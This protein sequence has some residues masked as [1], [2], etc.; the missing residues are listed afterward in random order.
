MAPLQQHFVTETGYILGFICS[1]YTLRCH[2]HVS[3]LQWAR[4]RQTSMATGTHSREHS[5]ELQGKV[6]SAFKSHVY[7]CH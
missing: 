2:L 5:R 3:M 7:P 4:V 6:Q 1:G